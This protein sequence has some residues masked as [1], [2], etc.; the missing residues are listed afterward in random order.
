MITGGIAC[1]L[2]SIAVAV[3]LAYFGMIKPELDYAER[4]VNA[5]R[6]QYQPV[7]KV[8]KAPHPA[9]FGWTAA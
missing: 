7:L 1:G 2:A 5:V 4:A 9:L 6:H 8:L 3:C